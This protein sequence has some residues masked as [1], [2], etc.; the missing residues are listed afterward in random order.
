MINQNK[1]GSSRGPARPSP[2]ASSSLAR[3][4]RLVAD[5]AL[6]G[7]VALVGSLA[8]PACQAQVDGGPDGE[9]IRQSSEKLVGGCACSGGK[10]SS[11]SFGDVPADG[12]YYVT[13]FGGG[14]DTQPM[15]CS[16][17]GVADGTWA[18]IADRSRFGCG[19]KV[20]MTANGKSCITLVGDCGPNRCVEEA[21]SGDKSC[22]SHKPVIDAS[23][24]ITKYLFGTSSAGWSDHFA[25]TATTVSSDAEIGCPGSETATSGGDGGSG[26]GEAGA[27]GSAGAGGTGPKNECEKNSD[28]QG[29]KAICDKSLQVFKCV[30]RKEQGDTCSSD[31]DCHGDVGGTSRICV[32]NLCT[33]GCR[34]DFDCDTSSTCDAKRGATGHCASLSGECVFDYPSVSIRGMAAPA[35]F[36]NSYKGCSASPSCV[37]DANN[38]TDAKTNKK[39]TFKMVQL[40]PHFSLYDMAHTTIAT[41][42]YIYVDPQMIKDLEATRVAYGS[43]MTVNSGYRSPL[44]QQHICQGI[45][46]ASSC[47]HTCAKCSNH[48]SGNAVDLKHSSPKC[49]L[50]SKACNPGKFHLIYNEKAGG[51]HLHIDLGSQNPVCAYKAFSCK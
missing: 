11:A 7:V 38:I 50:G 14:S 21:A 46:G 45:C 41:S 27:A 26:G 2:S 5:V 35:V 23:P 31:K 20:K 16:G 13:S 33:D 43:T 36:R 49:A 9:Q 32:S 3:T 24:F 48:S 47:P 40:S 37:I 29:E 42:P 44:H 39:L 25:A 12:K 17:A 10:C 6:V 30:T 19:T 28:C 34:T 8:M 22:Q 51:D 1:A 15:Q 4:V 18:Y